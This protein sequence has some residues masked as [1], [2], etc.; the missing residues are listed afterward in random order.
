MS[1]YGFYESIE[2]VEKQAREALDCYIEQKSEKI[3]MS[4]HLILIYQSKKQ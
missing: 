3:S 1:C 2:Y 4:L